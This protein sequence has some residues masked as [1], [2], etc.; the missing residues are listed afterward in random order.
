MRFTCIL[1]FISLL[2]KYF[3]YLLFIR[4][5]TWKIV[6]NNSYFD[7]FLFLS[8]YKC[9]ICLIKKSI[10]LILVLCIYIWFM[11]YEFLINLIRWVMLFELVTN[12]C[13]CIYVYTVCV[14]DLYLLFIFCQVRQKDAV[15]C[16]CYIVYT[17]TIVKYCLL[18]K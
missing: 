2:T 11:N 16:E 4:I 7:L 13:L 18:V 17:N 8:Y 9:I 14:I 1:L 10:D 6:N 12:I 5:L 3:M 15:N